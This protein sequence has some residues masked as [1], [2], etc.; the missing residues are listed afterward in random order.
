MESYGRAA[1][2]DFMTLKHHI[3]QSSGYK[4]AHAATFHFNLKPW[5]SVPQLSWV[6]AMLYHHQHQCE[7]TFQL[8]R[9]H[10][11]HSQSTCMNSVPTP[12]ECRPQSH[13]QPYHSSSPTHTISKPVHCNVLRRWHSQQIT[14]MPSVLQRKVA[15]QA[16][17]VEEWASVEAAADVVYLACYIA[18]PS[19]NS[20]YWYVACVED[21]GCVTPAVLARIPC[22]QECG[23][24]AHQLSEQA[25]APSPCPRTTDTSF[26]TNIARWFDRVRGGGV[27]QSCYGRKKTELTCWAMASPYFEANHPLQNMYSILSH[28]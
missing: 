11:G 2:P 9:P 1:L 21:A 18:Q 8:L 10:S 3:N 23:R 14:V 12:I 5:Q 15:A 24:C 17:E 13:S 26:Q 22:N 20:L 6:T 27:F 28:K 4:Q 25:H 16:M 7:P 19:S